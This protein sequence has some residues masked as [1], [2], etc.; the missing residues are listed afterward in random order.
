[1][2]NREVERK[3]ADA[4]AKTAPN[5]INGVL[6]RISDEKGTVLEVMKTKNNTKRYLKGAIAACLALAI[7]SGGG[8][9]YTRACTVSTVVSLDVNPSIELKINS[10]EKVISCSALN[11]EAKDVLAEMEGGKDLKGTDI[12]VAVNALIGALVRHGYLDSISSAI[13]VSV[14]DKDSERAAKL[15]QSVTETVDSVLSANSSAASVLS[16]T[17]S[18]DKKLDELAKKNNIS[19]GK[20]ALV[21]KVREINPSL[22][23]EALSALS[24]EEL[25]DLRETGAPALPIGKDKALEIA[26]AASGFSA[27]EVYTETDSDLDETPAHYDVE[28]KHNGTEYEYKIDAYTGE[29]LETKEEADDDYTHRAETKEQNPPIEAKLSTESGSEISLDKAKEVA[30]SYAGVTVEQAVVRKAKLNHDDGRVEYE[31]EFIVGNTEYEYDID[32]STG[33][34]ISSSVE[35]KNIEASQKSSGGD[36]GMEKAQTIALNHAGVKAADAVFNKA[37]LDYDDGRAEYDI[38]FVSGNTEYEYDIDASTGEVISS[39]VETK[40]IE[41]PQ[42]SS[43]GDIGEEKAQT[44]ALTHAGVGA[45]DAYEL[46][47][48]LD[49]D[50]G[51]TVYEIE[52]KSGNMEYEYKID[53]YTG[54]ILE[55]EAEIDD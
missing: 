27:D 6:S 39:S 54:A 11:D 46:E 52:F 13:L 8:A 35:T 2:N 4:I 7:M 45:G 31:L 26:M 50:D 24:V 19:G 1:M 55:H 25:K 44:I 36:I 49:H 51:V 14:E 37:K 10:L 9:Y 15:R 30:L 53:A 21:E 29:I 18:K 42:K 3:L 23:F 5:D 12:D 40:N 47:A 22:E 43:G 38:E 17:V 20:A 16:Q 32:A 34:V 41:A 28:I 33:A 48:E